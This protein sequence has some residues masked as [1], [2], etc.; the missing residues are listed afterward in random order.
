MP[1][2]TLER[3]VLAKSFSVSKQFLLDLEPKLASLRELYDS[4]DGVK[5]TLTQEELDEVVEL[6]GLDEDAGGQWYGGA[7]HGA[8]AGD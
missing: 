3:D 4:A 1:M 5:M 8:V 6:S 7:H 2:T